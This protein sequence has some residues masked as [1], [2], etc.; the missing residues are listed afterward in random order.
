MSAAT[1]LPLLP[2]LLI[3]DLEVV[4]SNRDFEVCEEMYSVRRKKETPVS[5]NLGFPSD[6]NGFRRAR[7]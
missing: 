7:S 1:R 3:N 5:E 4:E 6:D 2:V